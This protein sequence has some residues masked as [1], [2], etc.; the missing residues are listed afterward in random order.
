MFEDTIGIIRS[1]KSRGRKYNGEKKNVNN[2][3]VSFDKASHLWYAF[4]IVLNERSYFR[5]HC[6]KLALCGQM[7]VFRIGYVKSVFR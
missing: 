1:S 7:G 3:R 6:I 2:Y 5:F 4:M